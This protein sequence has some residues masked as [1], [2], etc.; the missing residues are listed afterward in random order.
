MAAR[1]KRSSSASCELQ[2]D[3]GVKLYTQMAM[4]PVAAA[5][6]FAVRMAMRSINWFVEPADDKP[7]A[8]KDAE[9]LD[10]C[11]DDMAMTFDDV[12]SQVFSMLK[13]G[14]S[15]CELVYKK[16]T[17]DKPGRYVGDAGR[18]R[19]TDGKIGW[20]RWQFIS[21]KSLAMSDRWDFDEY[22]RVQG[23]RQQAPPAWEP[24]YIPMEKALLFRTNVEFDNPEGL[25]ILRPMYSSWYFAEN[26]TEVEAIAAERACRSYTWVTGR[27]RTATIPTV[28]GL[29]E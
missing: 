11:M 1:F 16:R 23:F 27:T 3:G 21:P 13:F 10:E 17:G 28:T 24:V 4:H 29:W 12:I 15:L 20:R 6:L 7:D 8:E 9:F 22:G 19:Y 26:L 18:S 25:S 14:Y 5:V 2:G